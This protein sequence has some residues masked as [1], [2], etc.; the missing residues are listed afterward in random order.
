MLDCRA[1]YSESRICHRGGIYTAKDSIQLEHNNNT[2]LLIASSQLAVI[3]Y[4]SAA[5]IVA[6][7]ALTGHVYSAPASNPEPALEPAFSPVPET[8]PTSEASIFEK[9]W[10]LSCGP[11]D[12]PYCTT[13][14]A[15]A[16][17][18][19]LNSLGTQQCSVGQD[20]P[21]T[22]CQAA[23]CRFYGQAIG[24]SSASSYW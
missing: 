18:N 22:M 1:V 3:M 24:S 16:C 23:K 20:V 19:Y 2:L 10:T 6:I 8:G 4:F 17:V 9:R 5:S 11:S 14:N 13:A 15:Q 7:F 12:A 21:T